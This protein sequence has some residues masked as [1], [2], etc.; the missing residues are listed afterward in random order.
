[1]PRACVVKSD[2]QE[3]RCLGARPCPLPLLLLL[4]LQ[5]KSTPHTHLDG[6][7]ETPSLGTLL[8]SLK[9]LQGAQKETSG[10]VGSPTKRIKTRKH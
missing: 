3:R 7:T 10:I 1:M 2:Q 6:E 5:K 4:T 9:N 8:Q